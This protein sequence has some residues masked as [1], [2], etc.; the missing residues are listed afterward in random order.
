MYAEIATALAS[1][2]S[3][4]EIAKITSDVKASAQ[5]IQKTAELNITIL[6]LQEKMSTVLTEKDALLQ[7]KKDLEQ[8]ITQF[9]HWETEAARYELKEIALDVFMYTVKP[10]AAIGEPSHWLCPNCYEDKRKSIIQRD[11]TISKAF[12]AC[13]NCKHQFHFTPGFFGN[14]QT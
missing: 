10:S 4:A 11:S 3:L 5:V 12:Y 14:K 8:K 1:I 6:A 7:E 2:K 9:D 13:P